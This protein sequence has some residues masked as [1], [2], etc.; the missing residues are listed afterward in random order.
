MPFFSG[1]GTESIEMPDFRS[2]R[3]RENF[4]MFVSLLLTADGIADNVVFR[5]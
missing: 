1:M 5:L 4:E 2:Q 3:I